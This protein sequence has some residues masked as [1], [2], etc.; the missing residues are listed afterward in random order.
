[1]CSSDLHASFNLYILET[2]LPPQPFVNRQLALA[3]LLRLTPTVFTRD[4]RFVGKVMDLHGPL[5]ENRFR[6]AE[7][8]GKWPIAFLLVP[9]RDLLPVPLSNCT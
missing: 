5:L 8:T 7:W 3:V 6:N 1:M 9:R 4:W 2:P